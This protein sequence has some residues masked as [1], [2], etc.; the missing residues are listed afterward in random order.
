[1]SRVLIKSPFFRKLV[2]WGVIVART[3]TGILIFFQPLN[4]FIWFSIV[5]FWDAYFLQHMAGMSWRTYQKLDKKLDWFGYTSM[6]LVGIRFGI[7]SMV[8]PFFLFKLLGQIVFMFF[9]QQKVFLFFPNLLEAIFLWAVIFPL[10]GWSGGHFSLV[11]DQTLLM[12]FA[13]EIVKEFFLHIFW[14]NHLKKN[15]FPN[16]LRIFGIGK[17]VNWG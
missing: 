6:L 11:F 4:G 9:K 14:P 2:V 12:L 16:Y 8:I 15:G 10:I 17:E 5:D 13:L 7:A 3:F 1:M